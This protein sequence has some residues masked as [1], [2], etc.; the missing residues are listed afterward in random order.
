[1]P[2]AILLAD[3]TASVRLAVR[4][5]FENRHEGLVIRKA[6]DGMD[7]IEKAKKLLEGAMPKLNRADATQ[8]RDLPY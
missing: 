5:L 6:F 8:V 1:M 2:K 3:G 4:M 7:A